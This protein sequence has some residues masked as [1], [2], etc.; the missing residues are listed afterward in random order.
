MALKSR[1]LLYAAS[2]LHD[3]NTVK[4]KSA[5]LSS[6]PNIELVAYNGGDRTAR[7]QAAKN[8]AKAVL[9]AGNG[10]KLEL[11]A[12]VSAEEGKNNYVSLS[13]GG[14]SKAAEA[15]AAAAADLIFYRT[16]SGLYT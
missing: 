15:D 5:T 3:A 1:V 14:G 12:P 16:L 4:A 11:T 9:D 2:D 13:M 6:F 10:Y 8:A 7:W